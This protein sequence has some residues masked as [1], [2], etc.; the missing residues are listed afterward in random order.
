VLTWNRIKTEAKQILLQGQ[1]SD[2]KGKNAARPALKEHIINMFR[3]PASASLRA[4]SLAEVRT[5]LGREGFGVID[6]AKGRRDAFGMVRG[7]RG[8]R[9]R[10]SCGGLTVAALSCLSCARSRR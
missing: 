7:L 3:A 6:I 8:L 4:S 10:T 5:V 1:V 9:R 2:Q